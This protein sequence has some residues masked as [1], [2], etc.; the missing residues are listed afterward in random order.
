MSPYHAKGM[1]GFAEL[2]SHEIVHL[3]ERFTE[4]TADAVWI[5]ELGNEG[6]W[7]VISGDT[8]IARGTAEKAAWYESGL[9]IFFFAPPWAT[10]KFWVQS[11]ALVAWWDAINR[12]ARKT[13]SG[14]GFL[15]PK[16]GR[17]FREIYPGK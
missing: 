10:D 13:P 11:A 12:Q 1:R 2:Q 14:R 6:G 7:I 3:R 16:L 15:L 9:T 8:R 5:R 4:D 17:E